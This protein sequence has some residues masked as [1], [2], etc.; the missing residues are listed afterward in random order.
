MGSLGAGLSHGVLDVIYTTVLLSKKSTVLLPHVCFWGTMGPPPT[1]QFN[2]FGFCPFL[3]F[4]CSLVGLRG[5]CIRFGPVVG[6]S[7]PL[8]GQSV[9]RT[10][11]GKCCRNR[12]ESKMKV[13]YQLHA[14]HLASFHVCV[15]M[16]DRSSNQQTHPVAYLLPFLLRT[17]F[18]TAALLVCPATLRP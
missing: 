11:G 10:I 15:P 5:P 14:T 18:F 4:Q 12:E 16:G 8:L 17:P 3:S 2:S 6:S 1:S 9:K 7:D 13:Y